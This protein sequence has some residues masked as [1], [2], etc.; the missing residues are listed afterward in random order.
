[1]TPFLLLA[2]LLPWIAVGL[3]LAAALWLGLIVRRR[4]NES[5]QTSGALQRVVD[6]AGLL[7]GQVDLE[8]RWQRVPTGL[9][10]LLGRQESE[11]L[12][13]P[14]FECLHP[15]DQERLKSD[16]AE[17]LNGGRLSCALEARALR[18]DGSGRLFPD[19]LEGNVQRA[20]RDG[21]L[22]NHLMRGEGAQ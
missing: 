8:G 20:R 15:E 18:P 16:C 13:R 4:G 19:R 14:I 5:D 7:I 11:L 2:P 22:R 10:E 17:L 21:G 1:M 9:C 3:A 12:G 6:V